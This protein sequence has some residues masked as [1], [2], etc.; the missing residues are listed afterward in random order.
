MNILEVEKVA[1]RER[2]VCLV[3]RTVILQRIH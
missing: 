2:E 3:S 1:H